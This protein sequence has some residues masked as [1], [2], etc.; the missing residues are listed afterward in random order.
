MASLWL[1]GQGVTQRIEDQA[2]FSSLFSFKSLVLLVLFLEPRARFQSL[3]R[4]EALG[5][6]SAATRPRL[7]CPSQEAGLAAES[8]YPPNLPDRIIA[9]SRPVTADLD[10]STCL[11][12]AIKSK[13]YSCAKNGPLFLDFPVIYELMYSP[14]R[15]LQY[16]RYTHKIRSCRRAYAESYTGTG[17]IHADSRIPPSQ[18][19][20]VHS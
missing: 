4:Q 1:L 6:Q 8:V 16:L 3:V 7:T 2:P 13:I 10:Q 17:P 19:G 18:G 20:C 9:K 15:I 11:K 5:R 12:T 14:I